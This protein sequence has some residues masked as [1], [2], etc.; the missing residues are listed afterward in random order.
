MGAPT[1][2]RH[3]AQEIAHDQGFSLEALKAINNAYTPDVYTSS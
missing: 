2:T 3:S 1:K